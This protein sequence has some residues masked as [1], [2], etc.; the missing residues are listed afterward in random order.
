M[1]TAILL[2][3]VILAADNPDGV[4][5]RVLYGTA[6]QDEQCADVEPWI[7]QAAARAG[8]PSVLPHSGWVKLTGDHQ[9]LDGSKFRIDGKA[10]ERD[11][12]YVVEIDAC[13]GAP[14]D[15]KVA[16][17]PG[18]RRIVKLTDNAAPDNVFVALKAPVSRKAKER[19]EAMKVNAS[20]FRLDMNYNGEQGKP[21]YRMIVSV[22]AISRRRSSPFERIVQVEQDEAIRIIDHLARDGFFDHAVD[23]RTNSKIPA[24]AMPGYTM[25][26][27]AGREQW[28][29]DLG[30]GLP[31]IHR[32]DALSTV[33]PEHGRKDIELLLG[34]LSGLRAQWEREHPPFAGSVGREGSR[35]QFSAEG[36]TTIVD[37]TSRFGID[38]A[39]IRRE[40]PKWPGSILVRLHLKGLELFNV[41]NGELSVDWSVSST[42]N[43]SSR[44]F[45]RSGG[46]ETALDNKSPYHAPVRIIGGDRRIPLVDGYFEVPLPSRLFARNPVEI[47]LEWIDFYRN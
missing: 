12:K 30:W 36:D 20:T 29:Q 34:R 4:Q 14:L 9:R 37:I 23:L 39:T 44:V 38:Q 2:C 3:S 40:S 32:L 27:G 11:G 1:N 25:K 13:A 5:A 10:T 17:K 21:F 6:S 31:M 15:R 8:S 33:L 35:V 7:S 24:P 45:L 16:L 28:F 26:A 46:E 47:K 43:H 42:G 22:P 18:E 41:G 19:A